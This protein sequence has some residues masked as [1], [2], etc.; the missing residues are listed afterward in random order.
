[1]KTTDMKPRE[2]ALCKAAHAAMMAN[3]EAGLVYDVVKL[4]WVKPEDRAIQAGSTHRR[5][6]MNDH[7]PKA[8]APAK[9]KLARAEQEEN[10]RRYQALT[11]A[12]K[13]AAFARSLRGGRYLDN[14]K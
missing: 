2:L 4:S 9:R 1:M 8:K 6:S 12:E 14:K 11:A 10:F 3:V 7:G 13:D 5:E